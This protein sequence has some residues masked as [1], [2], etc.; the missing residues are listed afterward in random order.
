MTEMKH[1][2]P[3]QRQKKSG[4]LLIATLL[5]IAAVPLPAT[6]AGFRITNQSLGAVGLSGARTAFT[7]GPDAGYYNPANMS[8]SADQWQVETSL[9]ILDLPAITYQDHRTTLLNASSQSERFFMPLVHAVSPAQGP[10]R[11]GF[12]L[13]YPYGLSKKW[14]QP[15][16][17]ASAQHFSLFVVEASPSVAFTPLSWLSLGG[18]LRLVHGR[19]EVDGEVLNPPFD[20]LTP[21]TSISRSSDGTDTRPGYN[22]AM[23]I[24]PHDR[25]AVAATYRSEI[26]LDLE[27]TSTL[28]AQAGSIPLAAYSGTGTVGVTLPAVLSLA[29]AYT[30][31]RL[32]VELGWD[33]TFWSSFSTLDFTYE[34]DLL[35][36]V[37]DG[38]DRPITK[39][40]QDS[41]A[42]RCGLS[43]VWNHRWTSTLGFTYDHTPVP[44][45]TLGFDLPDADA[46]I[47]SA[48]IRYRYAADLEFG[49]S[50]MYHH[51]KNRSIT[52]DGTGGLP[53]IDGTFTD[54]GAHA[55]TLGL[56]T[57]F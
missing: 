20:Q 19:G 39:N 28:R 18:G 50:Y 13:T 3:R 17:R 15:L 1:C 2:L 40:W 7:P 6:A 36:T 51:T 4:P 5:L 43:Y 47:Y 57:T 11:F 24:Q 55:L 52:N 34:E 21:L 53:G 54:G 26:N 16:P 12:S 42:Y 32:T 8:F 31:D 27:G 44:A 14:Q 56:L 25:L 41:D 10:L 38:F 49:L 29:V 48:G 30:F 9:T 45:A 35:G 33:R 37:F 46:L 23:T 22:L